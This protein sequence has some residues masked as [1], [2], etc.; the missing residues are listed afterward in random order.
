VSYLLDTCVLSEYVKR[1]PHAGVMRWLDAQPESALF[2]S[3]ISLAEL[4]KGI[5]KL[6]SQPIQ[7]IQ[8][9]RHA[10][11]TLWLGKVTAR[12]AQRTLPVD[13][14]VWRAW[15]QQSAAAELQGQPL[16]PMDGLIMATAQSQGL[17]LVTRNTADFVRFPQVVNPWAFE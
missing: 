16:P 2:I 7:P 4:E 12:F 5:F 10:T 3:A 17:S 15:S 9:N 8:A 14:A 1:T 13:A 6:A 11:L